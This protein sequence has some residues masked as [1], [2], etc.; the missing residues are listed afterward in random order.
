MTVIQLTGKL[1]LFI[2]VGYV[3]RKLK[4]MGD[5]FDRQLSKFL[6]AIPLPCMI[7]NSF[8]IEYS[9]AYLLNTPIL[10]GLS[11][12][13]MALLYL[14]TSL[15][16]LR[17]KDRDL[18]RTVRFSLLFS[19][20]TFLGLPV[21][22]EL[23]GPE[24]VFSYVIFTLP[25]RV[26]F[27]GG[28]AVMLGKGGERINA[29]ETIRKFLCEPVIAVFIGFVLYVTQLRLPEV[30]QS[31]IGTLGA[32]ASPLGLLLCGTIIA[33][34]DWRGIRKQPGAI[35]VA[36]LRLTVIPAF[37]AA[38]FL[39]LGVDHELI[40]S[41]VYFFAMP[42]ASFTPTFLLRYNPDAVEARVSAGYMVVASTVLCVLTIPGWTLLLEKLL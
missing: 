25:I 26:M 19:N 13:S 7:I 31:A 3:A 30:L 6:M 35:V 12:G 15:A 27:Y 32:M 36:V 16:T 8:H 28:A 24:A 20:F 14:L 38:L 5:G 11:V 10:I 17:M 37:A 40:R 21:V 41:S 9:A 39:L 1:I 18:R 34:A 33:D 4:V 29:K 22:S 2:A 23:Y 42:V